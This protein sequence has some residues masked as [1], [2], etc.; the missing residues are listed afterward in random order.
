MEFS[1][2]N[3]YFSGGN[4]PSSENFLT[5]REMEPSSP[6]ISNFLIFEE[7]TCKASK[8]KNFKKWNSYIFSKNFFYISGGNLQSP[9]NPEKFLIFREL[10]VSSPKI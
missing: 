5:F 10:E 1:K 6:K 3:F 4:F 7:G 2:K 8:T 9:E